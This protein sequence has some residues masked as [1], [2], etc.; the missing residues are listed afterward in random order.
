VKIIAHSVSNLKEARVALK[1]GVDY[2]EVDVSKR[3]LLPKFVVQHSIVKGILGVGPI[4]ASLLI[5]SIRDKLFL[6]LKRATFSLSFANKFAHLLSTFKVKGVRICGFNWLI[7]SK[8]CE[9]N[10]LL[11]FYTLKTEEHIEKIRKLSPSLKKPAG[12]S[13]H[14]SLINKKFLKEF[15][16]DQTQIWSW[17]INDLKMAKQLIGLGVDGIISDNWGSMLKLQ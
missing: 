7:I 17:T 3:I 6:D 2:I 10:N 8:L 12:F 11:P 16:D 15:K 9:G 13:V 14:Y 4:L 5:P 1:N